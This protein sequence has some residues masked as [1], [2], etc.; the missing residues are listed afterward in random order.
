MTK[1]QSYISLF[2][3]AALSLTLLSAVADRFGY[4]GTQSVWG[5]WQNFV[6]YTGTLT[7]YLPASLTE[8]AAIA[9]TA[10]EGIFGILLLIG[11][12]TKITAYLTGTLLL[13][14]ALSMVG[15]IGIKATLD[16]SVWVGSAASFLL[17]VQNAYP[18]SIDAFLKK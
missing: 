8:A 1:Q 3:R 9:A 14:F 7:F 18:F 17:A 11:Y 6:Q 15:S 2:F 10:A 13:V 16:Y 12:K 4:W 5:N